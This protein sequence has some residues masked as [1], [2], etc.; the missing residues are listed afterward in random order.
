MKHIIII[1]LVATFIF[2]CNNTKE[3][4]MLVKGEIKNLKKGTVYLLKMKD[5]LLVTVDSLILNGVNTFTLSDEVESPEMYY[6]SLDRSPSKEISFFGEKGTINISTKLDKFKFGA[7]VNGLSNQQLL[8]EYNKMK[9]QYND[10]RLDLLKAD[11]EAK[12]DEDSLQIDS[13]QK[14]IKNLTKS[15]YLYTTNFAVNHGDKEVAPFLALTELY[16]ANLRLLDTIKNSLSEEI[17]A[18]KYGKE[19]N[20]YLTEIKKEKISN[21]E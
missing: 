2:S 1:L 13:I 14:S 9:S 8:D 6:L 19:F 5:T 18:S 10:K 12:R 7:I 15:R 21:E 11:F 17:Q 16:N 3:N 20:S 4:T